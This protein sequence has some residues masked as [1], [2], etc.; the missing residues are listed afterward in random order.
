MVGRQILNLLTAVRS[1]PLQPERK[2]MMRCLVL[3]SSFEFL[4]FTDYRG[5]ICAA[6]TDKAY[7]LEEYDQIVRSPSIS[8]RIPAV[9]RLKH[10]V[11]VTYDKIAYVSYTKRNVHLRDKYTCQYCTEKKIPAKLGIDHVL[12]ESRGGENTWHNTVSSC[13]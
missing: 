3:N 1:L 5:A 7:V 6:Y 8:M 2:E 10:Y 12:P 4:G 11:K 9:I 13:Q